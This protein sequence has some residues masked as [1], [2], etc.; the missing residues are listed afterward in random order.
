[1]CPQANVSEI[2]LGGNGNGEGEERLTDLIQRKRT[3][4]GYF[5]SRIQT[6]HTLTGDETSFHIQ[7][8]EYNSEFSDNDN[9]HLIA[10]DPSLKFNQ[11]Q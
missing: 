11:K 6:P 10:G 2:V 1:M 4:G 7:V 8:K 9:L 5:D 3:I